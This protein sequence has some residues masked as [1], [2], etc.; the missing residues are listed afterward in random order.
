[1]YTVHVCSAPTQPPTRQHSYLACTGWERRISLPYNLI[2][3]FTDTTNTF[4]WDSQIYYNLQPEHDIEINLHQ[5]NSLVKSQKALQAHGC[6]TWVTNLLIIL[7][8]LLDWDQTALVPTRC[9]SDSHIIVLAYSFRPICPKT[10]LKKA[11][12]K[13]NRQQR[14]ALCP[15][16]IVQ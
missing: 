8:T 2:S 16:Y 3:P 4:T 9:F 6:R 12:S 14:C 10:L 11:L 7:H 5:L 1:M 15:Y 13:P